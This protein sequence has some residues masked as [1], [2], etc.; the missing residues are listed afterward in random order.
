MIAYNKSVLKNTF[1]IKYAEDLLDKNFITKINLLSIK[2]QLPHLN[3]SS[4]L[5]RIGFFLLGL[6]LISSIQGFLALITIGL[7]NDFKLQ[8]VLGLIISI[9]GAEFLSRKDYFRHGL[10]DAFIISIPFSA[11]ISIGIITENIFIGFLMLALFGIVCAIRYVHSISA[12]I[13]II[14]IIGLFVDLV[15]EH[16]LINTAFLPFIILACGL[17]FYFLNSF[18][19]RKESNFIYD[20]VMFLVKIVSLL[21]MYFSMNYL[22]VR[23]LSEV[24]M[25]VKVT[26]GNDISFAW[27]FYIL[28]FA[29]PIG[30]VFFGVKNH[31]RSKLWIGIFTLGFGVFTIRF[32]YAI[33]PIEIAMIIG[34]ILLFTITYFTIIQIQNKTTGVTFQPDLGSGNSI[35]S[36]AQALLV[37]TLL[38]NSE[39]Q[40]SESKMPFGGGEF[41]G[42]GAGGNY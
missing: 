27:I 25:N 19:G 33:L 29:I 15:I 28:T 31:D 8:L 23:E 26:K 12:L 16:K 7:T 37:A 3:S 22:V 6:F 36:N 5:I 4:F 10:D 18:F 30:Y 39:I 42:G 17:F 32:Y 13:G 14:G 34:G 41:S 20:D 21:L 2:T 9:I 40:N 38:P 24:L 11:A 35:M 1:A